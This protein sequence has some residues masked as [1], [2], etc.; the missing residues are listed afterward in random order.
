MA[1]SGTGTAADPYVVD[2]WTDFL[3]VC[4]ISTSTYVKWAD[5]ENKVVD[6]NDINPRGFTNTIET[7]GNIDFNSWELRNMNS[8]ARYVLKFTGTNNNKPTVQNLK[9]T[10][11]RHVPETA[12]GGQAFV[13]EQYVTFDHISISYEFDY[14]V[15][16]ASYAINATSG[17]GNYYRIGVYA[18]GMVLDNSWQFMS[19]GRTSRYCR[20][21]CDVQATNCTNL[22]TGDLIDSVVSGSI[23]IDNDNVTQILV[24]GSNSTLDVIRVQSNKAIRYNGKGI[25]LKVDKDYTGDIVRPD[26]SSWDEHVLTVNTAQART[27]Q[28]AILAAGFPLHSAID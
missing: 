3:T 25:A 22:V 21:H 5:S 2:N 1:A 15:G 12:T 13:N 6:F 23:T 10:N 27:E 16:G 20:F 11:A 19:T 17:T 8:S 9:I 4:N 18:Y 28:A 24:G 7:K 14:S 26:I